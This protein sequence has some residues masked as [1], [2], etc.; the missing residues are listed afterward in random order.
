MRDEDPAWFGPEFWAAL[1]DWLEQA[2][3]GYE[4]IANSPFGAAGVNFVAGLKSDDPDPAIR[5]ARAYLGIEEN[6]SD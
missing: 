6:S 3:E 5:V 2:A 1:A 4:V